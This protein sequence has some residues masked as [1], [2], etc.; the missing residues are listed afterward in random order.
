MLMSPDSSSRGSFNQ[1]PSTV[2]RVQVQECSQSQQSSAPS[3]YM[4]SSNVIFLNKTNSGGNRIKIESNDTPKVLNQQ[5][6]QHQLYQQPRPQTPEYTKSFPVMDTTVAS[7][8]K[9][10]PDLNIEF[11]GTTVLCRVCGDKASGFHYGVHSCEGC[12]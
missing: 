2:I 3:T 11:D 1:M 6:P 10:E 8:V 4:T 9:G 7:S 5:P 12:K